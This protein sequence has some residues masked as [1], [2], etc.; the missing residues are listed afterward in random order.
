MKKSTFWEKIPFCYGGMIQ[1][2]AVARIEAADFELEDG[3]ASYV[4]AGFNA[5]TKC[6]KRL[7]DYLAAFFMWHFVKN[8]IAT[9][10]VVFLFLHSIPG[11]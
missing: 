2:E 7:F 4:V 10:E 3:A 5:L 8:Q 11:I 1:R 9:E 6:E